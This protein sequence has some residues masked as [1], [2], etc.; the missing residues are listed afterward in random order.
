MEVLQD[1]F[2]VKFTSQH[3][4]LPH[5]SKVETKHN[6]DGVLVCEAM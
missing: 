1:I 3:L 2:T 4:A 5:F 6:E